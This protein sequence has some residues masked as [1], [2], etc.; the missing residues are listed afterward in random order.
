MVI[1]EDFKTKIAETFYDKEFT[2]YTVGNTVDDE[3]D[4]IRD[5]LVEGETFYG[6]IS[7]NI[8]DQIQKDYGLSE[9]VDATITTETEV[10]VGSIIEYNSIKYLVTRSLKFDSH[11]LL[12]MKEWLSRS[13]T[14]TSA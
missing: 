12:I 7:F 4:V 11:Y 14:L 6:N 10:P 1:P 3:G 5:N 2:P 13:S 8:G 9:Q